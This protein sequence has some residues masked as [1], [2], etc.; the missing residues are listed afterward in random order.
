MKYKDF[1]EAVKQHIKEY[2]PEEWQTAE[3]MVQE[4]PKNNGIIRHGMII[5]KPGASF[6]PQLYLKDFY[7]LYSNGANMEE[8]LNK[9]G[10]EYLEALR[11][12]PDFGTQD[13]TYEKM[14]SRLI[15]CAVNAEKNKELLF[16]IPHQKVEDLAIVYRCIMTEEGDRIGNLLVNND[17]LKH[18]GILPNVLHEHAKNNM[19]EIF[20][21]ELHSMEY[22]MSD[23]M[24]VPFEETREGMENSQ[25]FVLSNTKRW[26]G[27][28]YLFCPEVLDVISKELG[29]NF[30]ILP[31]SIHELIL[32][33]QNEDSNI[34]ALRDMVCEVNQTQVVEEERLSNEV[35]QYDAK[36]G[37][38]SMVSDEKM[39]QGMY[40]GM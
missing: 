23:I 37:K 40:F 16:S 31:S 9:I 11:T 20:P 18:W 34:Q 25:M 36:A 39:Q 21:Y 28:S 27:A 24:G 3:V 1:I 30:L 35:Y 29:G 38:M 14:R 22:I 17:H 4:Q 26:Q 10:R 12:A 33:R 8:T 2:L 7:Q 15:L 13:F 6:A 19:K 5:Q 32:I